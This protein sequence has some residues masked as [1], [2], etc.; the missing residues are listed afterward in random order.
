MSTP[1]SPKGIARIRP[2]APLLTQPMYMIV[3]LRDEICVGVSYA[4]G[5]DLD[6]WK[7]DLKAAGW[8][9][10]EGASDPEPERS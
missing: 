1:A 6:A 4:R 8:Q 2:A 7:R 5:D 9:L 3:Y 10:D